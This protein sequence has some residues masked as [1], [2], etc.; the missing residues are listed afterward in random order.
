MS[1]L[2]E[3]PKLESER[4]LDLQEELEEAYSHVELLE[5]KIN[6]HGESIAGPHVSFLSEDTVIRQLT[7]S[8]GHL[9][10]V[11]IHHQLGG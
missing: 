2:I 1:N 9:E 4:E 6:Q 11:Q 8:D 10:F 3:T 5:A 7:T